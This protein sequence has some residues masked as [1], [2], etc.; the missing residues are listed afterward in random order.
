[1][2][3]TEP[4]ISVIVAAYKSGD[5][6]NK[7][8]RSLDAQTLPQ[9]Q[10]ETII[11]DDGSPDDTYER[12]LA[13]AETRPNLRVSRIENSGWPSRPRN[14]ATEQ[15][16]GAY[17]LYMDHDDS[18]YPSALERIVEF[19]DETGADLISPKESKTSEVWWAMPALAGGN[20]SDVKASDA[21]GRILPM[22][23]HKVYRRE[24]LREN[25][26][27]F[28]EGRRQLWEDVYFNVEAW[29]KATRGVA[30][31]ADTPVYL[32]HESGANNSGSYGATDAEYWDRLDELFEFIDR[33]LSGPEFA[34]VHK[35]MLV[36]QYQGRVLRRLGR[37]LQDAADE[38]VAEA[39]RRARAIQSRYIPVEW[40]PRL[41][42][43]AQLRAWLLRHDRPDLL[44]ELHRAYEGISMT[45]T[46]QRAEW[47]D[48]TLELATESRW[49]RTSPDGLGFV[50]V[51]DRVLMDLPS[52][53][54]SAVPAE[55]LDVTDRLERFGQTFGVRARAEL[56]T[57]QLPA[58]TEVSFVEVGSSGASGEVPVEVEVVAR[59]VVRL[60]PRTA[61]FGAPLAETVWDLTTIARWDAL[62]RGSGLAYPGAA[63]PALVD[64]LA[65][66]AYATKGGKLAVDLGGSLREVALDAQLRVPDSAARE[67]GRSTS[68]KLGLGGVHV[69]GRT[70]RPTQLMWSRG[71]GATVSADAT[72]VGGRLVGEESGAWLLLD[73]RPAQG[74]YRLA[75]VGPPAQLS[76]DVLII[77]PHL[78][79]VRHRPPRRTLRALVAQGV[80]GVARAG[81]R[82]GGR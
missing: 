13:L 26:I 70:D 53:I 36:H 29:A 46:V 80:R 16:R 32:W 39:M 24:F 58:E 59:S 11:I 71:A 43:F 82:L 48:G 28:P 25:G 79:W 75:R 12:L 31:L 63:L 10:F 68:L 51:G 41:G 14:L 74:R 67:P 23:P 35:T 81:R 56:I 1:M 21:I 17:V 73:G 60:D 64:G 7:V 54:A 55:A 27:R 62:T 22:V 9:D 20:A 47:V 2:S 4:K 77:S 44:L 61:A 18:L 34:V 49:Q 76:D 19:A 50:K 15:A 57:W 78:I 65:G 45:T 37:Q 66:V 30:V 3:P 6:I 72:P 8:I 69:T 38:E 5:G 42:F 33:T 52:S 40:D